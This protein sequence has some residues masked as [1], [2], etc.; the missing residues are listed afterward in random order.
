MSSAKQL[1]LQPPAICLM[2]DGK[3]GGPPAA[4]VHTPQVHHSQ[5][6]TVWATQ[7]LCRNIKVSGSIPANI[8]LPTSTF[9]VHEMTE[10]EKY[11]FFFQEEVI[12]SLC[13]LS[14]EGC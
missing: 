1:K 6:F 8:S 4:Q 11:G 13:M 10:M 9:T 7:R 12:C 2:G 3:G 5:S 14:P